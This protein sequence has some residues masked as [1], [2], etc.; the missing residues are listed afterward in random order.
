[1]S[2]GGSSC[3]YSIEHIRVT[4]SLDWGMAT[5]VLD[6]SRSAKPLL[7]CCREPWIRWM[8][9]PLVRPLLATSEAEVAE[10]FQT[11]GC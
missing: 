11:V 5:P 10:L 1:M 8:N 4:V 6:R 9:S 3:V 7:P 2:R